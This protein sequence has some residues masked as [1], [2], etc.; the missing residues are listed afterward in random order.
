LVFVAR[1]APC[2]WSDRRAESDRDETGKARQDMAQVGV[3]DGSQTGWDWGCR[4]SDCLPCVYGLCRALRIQTLFKAAWEWCAG[5]RRGKPI[6]VVGGPGRPGQGGHGRRDGRRNRANHDL[7]HWIA[8]R[9]LADPA[10][11]FGSGPVPGGLI[12]GDWVLVLSG[13]K[14]PLGDLQLNGGVRGFGS[15]GEGGTA[16]PVHRVF[17]FSPFGLS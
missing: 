2:L 1:L 13:F 16:W 17:R 5:R 14:C 7:I 8:L 15:G 4:I 9:W 11:R 3:M 12:K 6:K 10:L